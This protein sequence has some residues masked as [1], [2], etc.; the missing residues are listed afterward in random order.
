MLPLWSLTGSP[1]FKVASRQFSGYHA[2]GT[3]MACGSTAVSLG[4]RAGR[5][6][7]AKKML[8]HI[9]HSRP[10]LIDHTAQFVFGRFELLGPVP[11]LLGI[12]NV[13]G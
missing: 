3:L 7:P 12:V 13:N 1:P 5:G 6:K 4:S 11:Q 2:A 10:H 8:P 9:V